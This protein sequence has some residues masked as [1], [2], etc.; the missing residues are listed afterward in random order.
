MAEAGVREAGEEDSGVECWGEEVEEVGGRTPHA[1]PV[2]AAAVFAQLGLRGNR[3]QH[4]DGGV[5]GEAGHDLQDE[6]RSAGVAPGQ[7]VL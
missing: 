2:C 1:R 7:C 3:F 4:L 6:H 5:K